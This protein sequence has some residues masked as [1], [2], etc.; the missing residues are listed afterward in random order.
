M[1]LACLAL[2]IIYAASPAHAQQKI[3]NVEERPTR[4]S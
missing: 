1:R 2:L 4:G 3:V